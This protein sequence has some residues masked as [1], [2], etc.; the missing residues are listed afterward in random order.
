MTVTPLGWD[1][2]C[3]LKIREPEVPAPW[4]LDPREKQDSKAK[5]ETIKSLVKNLPPPNHDTMKI[6][7]GH[8]TKSIAGVAHFC[9]SKPL[10]PRGCCDLEQGTRMAKLFGI[11]QN[12]SGFLGVYAKCLS[13]ER[14][15][16]LPMVMKPLNWTLVGEVGLIVQINYSYCE[17]RANTEA[18]QNLQREL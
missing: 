9:P 13:F 12:H 16:A 4:F 18:E 14:A 1:Q 3:S 6:L 8:L 15:N 5:V 7:F 10:A 2:D 17:N 11:S